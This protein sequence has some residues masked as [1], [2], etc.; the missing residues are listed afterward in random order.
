MPISS[1]LQLLNNNYP[2]VEVRLRVRWNDL[3]GFLDR[4]NTFF[5]LV[6][7]RT[8]EVLW[9]LHEYRGHFT[10]RSSIDMRAGTTCTISPEIFSKEWASVHNSSNIADARNE[11]ETKEAEMNSMIEDEER[12]LFIEFKNSNWGSHAG[13]VR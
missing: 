9:F 13:E 3:S 5:L 6:D 1:D 10:S 11:I 4:Y 12:L 2:V 8:R 7:R